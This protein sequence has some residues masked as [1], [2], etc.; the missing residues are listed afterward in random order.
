MPTRR[1]FLIQSAGVAAAANIPIAKGDA[2]TQEAEVRA[3]PP[4]KEGVFQPVDIKR[5][6][7]GGEFG[8]RVD[9]MIEGNILK[10]D[11]DKTFLND[12]RQ[13]GKGG[14]THGYV[15][16]GKFIDAVVR[17]AA[18]TADARLV[19]LKKNAIG[20]LLATQDRDGYIG[21]F[22]APEDRMK[23]VWDLHE[24][25]YLIWALVADSDL[26]GERSSLEG[27][28][29]LA[30]YTMIRLNADPTLL[31]QQLGQDIPSGQDTPFTVAS[32]GFDRALLSLSRA[33]GQAKY[34]DFV[35]NTLKLNEYHPEVLTSSP[36]DN[37]AYAYMSHC[38][39]QLDLY[40]ETGNPL[41]LRAT[42]NAVNFMRKG[43]G[44][45]VT[46]SCSDRE[47]WHDTQSGLAKTSETCMSAYLARAMNSMLQLY[48]DSIYGDILERDIY[49]ALFAAT[50]PDGSQ[51]RYFTPFEGKRVYDPFSPRFCCANNNKR[52]LA[53]L[54][55][56]MYY[57]T[58]LGVAVNL[59]N[60]STATMD[61]SSNVK[62]NIEQQTDYPSSGDVKLKIDPSKAA[63][64]DVRLRIPRWCKTAR[65]SI[66][67]GTAQTVAG[68]Q[69][70]ILEREWKTGDTIE[71]KMP[72]EWRFVRG[73]R[74]QVG[75][76]AV[77]RGPVL[78]TF[79]PDRNLELAQQPDFDLRLVGFDSLKV[80]SQARDDSVRPGGVSCTVIA[81]PPAR[82]P[83]ATAKTVPMVLTEYPDP[84]GQNIYFQVKALESPVLTDDELM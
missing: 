31:A 6:T 18:G 30:D 79:N 24:S 22:E 7:L 58:A 15:G 12:F 57:R 43:N 69:F 19:A 39:A 77:L 21:I 47:R 82:V 40:R 49:N 29:A 66:N 38:Q 64:F 80:E 32:I 63:R 27:A 37:H 5:V 74:S 50:S 46:G 34:R 20:D 28:R 16:F 62:L 23:V 59:Y 56:W 9:H 45:L 52:F 26:F 84:N 8:R 41:L 72:M 71:L 33:T 51:T 25:A 4:A 61:L 1:T 2:E 42:H 76:A 53:E 44:L 68:G 81:T 67:G 13:R 54:R 70:H 75:R 60:A 35:I 17:L 78:F 73:R 14:L 11:I 36:V 55:G 48:G 3:A 83:S 65:V 10:I